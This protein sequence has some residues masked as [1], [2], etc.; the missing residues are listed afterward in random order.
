MISEAA[1]TRYA[2]SGEVNIGSQV[3]GARTVGCIRSKGFSAS[4]VVEGV[5]LGR[6]ELKIPGAS[7][8]PLTCPLPRSPMD[9]SQRTR[10]MP[11]GPGLVSQTK[12]PSRHQGYTTGL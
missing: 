8:R 1:Q 6:H 5:T 7:A 12:S 9:G 2:P 10:P 4:G 11:P 3:F